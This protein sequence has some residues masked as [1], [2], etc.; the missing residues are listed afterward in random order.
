[1]KILFKYDKDG[2]YSG[3]CFFQDLEGVFPPSN[4]TEVPLSEGADLEGNFF[5]WDGNAWV[6]E[7]KPSC[8]SD[9][10]GTVISHESQTDHDIEM[11][12]LIQ[13]FGSE[14]GYRLRDRSADL[15]W[16]V[17]LIPQ[18]EIDLNAISQELSEFDSQVASLKD[19]MATA[20]LQGDEEQIASLKA[21]Y[22]TLMGA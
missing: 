1:M 16:E 6:A 21:E 11:R 9:L 8:A 10:V 4:T 13:K 18:E 22:Q 15:S 2:Y 3:Q 5:K 7:A 12:E 20:M 19:R 17:E 14:G